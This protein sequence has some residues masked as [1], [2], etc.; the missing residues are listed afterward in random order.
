MLKKYAGHEDKL[1][2]KLRKKYV[3]ASGTNRQNSTNRRNI[4]AS[5]P[6]SS[7]STRNDATPK[8]GQ[9]DATS[10]FRNT[11]SSSFKSS[12]SVKINEKRYDLKI[13]FP[14]TMENL[15]LPESISETTTYSEV[16]NLI[17]EEFDDEDLPPN[18]KAEDYCFFINA[19][20]ITKTR[21]EKENF[22]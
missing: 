15:V 10:S 17:A 14:E 9:K 21:E 2:E 1:L 16:W 8:T 3:K 11:V 20:R 18:F 19:S 12:V 22:P 4:V 5:P 13:Q 6:P 7:T